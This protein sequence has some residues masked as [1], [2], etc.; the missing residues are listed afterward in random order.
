MHWTRTNVRK[1]CNRKHSSQRGAMT[2]IQAQEKYFV[3]QDTVATVFID[4]LSDM[5]LK[6]KY[7]AT[8]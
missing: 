2:V 7:G 5:K 4:D 1:N 6:S 3:F 8:L